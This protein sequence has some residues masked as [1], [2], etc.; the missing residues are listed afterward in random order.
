M[1]IVIL[2][3]SGLIGNNILENLSKKTSFNL[4][5]VGRNIKKKPFR[6]SRIKY[7]KWD[8]ETFKKK[9]LLFLKQADI[10]I[11]CV[12]KT[13]NIDGYLE[14]I[15][16]IFPKNLVKYII[17][18][19]LKVR[20]IHLS[21]VAVYGGAQNYLGQKKLISENSVNKINDLYSKTK[22]DGDLLIKNYTKRKLNKHFSYT[23]LRISNVFGGKE[24][25]N[26]YRFLMFSLKFRFWIKSFNDVIFNFVNVNDVTQAV[27]LIISKLQVS[28]NKTYIVSDDCKQ[29]KVFQIHQNLL[30]KKNIKFNIPISLIKFLIKLLPLPKKIINF[31]LIISSRV[32][33][34][35][36]KI[37]KELNFSPRFSILEKIKHLNER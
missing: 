37:K 8:F 9:N 3:Y 17:S 5:C 18:N 13:E 20:L 25:T 26:L 4:T 19:K 28:K 11:N 29:Y 10:I 23:I 21:S 36:K 7:Y 1:K 32:S 35:N 34:S 27:N 30:K 31:L 14:R 2:G 33:Y 24:K 12:G 15:N 16:V 6:N 22:L